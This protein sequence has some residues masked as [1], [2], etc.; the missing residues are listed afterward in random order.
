MPLSQS[1]APQLNSEDNKENPNF[2]YIWPFVNDPMA[3]QINLVLIQLIV[4]DEIA[5]KSM[6]VLDNPFF[7]DHLRNPVSLPY[8]MLDSA[9]SSTTFFIKPLKRLFLFR[10]LV[11][12]SHVCNANVD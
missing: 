1:P 2:H 7:L 4:D 5:N 3:D 6:I 11:A 12:S 9:F 8:I 10:K